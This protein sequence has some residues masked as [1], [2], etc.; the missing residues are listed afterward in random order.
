MKRVT[1]AAVAVLP[2]AGVVQ[3]FRPAVTADLKV[4]TT[5]EPAVTTTEPAVTKDR[6]E[7]KAKPASTS[8]AQNR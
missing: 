8:G 6:D 2:L 1:I 5:T 7:R 3:A 4:R